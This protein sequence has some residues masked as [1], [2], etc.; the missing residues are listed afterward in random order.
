VSATLLDGNA[1]AKEIKAQVKEEVAAFTEAHGFAPTLAVLRVGSDESVAGYARAIEKNCKSVGIAF[2]AVELGDDAT[3][4]EVTLALEALNHDAGVHGIMIL[5]PTPKQI[6]HA[7]LVD[8]LD[9]NKDADGVHPLNAG[10]LSQ[11]KTPCFVPATPAGGIRMLEQ[12]G[13]HGVAA[14]AQALHRYDRAQSHRRPA[15]RLPNGGHTVRWDW[16]GGNG[17]SRLGEARRNRRR[18]RHDLHR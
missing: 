3:Q 8:R 17:Q 1:L 6:D 11:Q 5:E 13:T 10:R 9:P 16:A 18:F 2:R 14:P 12:A 7:A 4:T 15:G